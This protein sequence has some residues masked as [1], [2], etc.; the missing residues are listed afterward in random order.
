MFWG[1]GVMKI[2]IMQMHRFEAVLWLHDYYIW[3]SIRLGRVT[4]N[5]YNLLKS[6]PFCRLNK[7][8]SSIKSRVLNCG[9][10]F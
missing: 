9:V 10:Y 5:W 7:I 4:V 1:N 8:I 3:K 2:S 6:R